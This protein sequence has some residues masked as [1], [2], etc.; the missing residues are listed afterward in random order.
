MNIGSLA[1]L[2]IFGEGHPHVVFGEEDVG[3]LEREDFFGSNKGVEAESEEG[4]VVEL[5]RVVV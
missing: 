2:I 5:K 4:V 3:P 1:F